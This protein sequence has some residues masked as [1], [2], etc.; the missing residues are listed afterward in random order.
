MPTKNEVN[1]IKETKAKKAAI[2]ETKTNNRCYS[3]K[4]TENK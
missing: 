3:L 1:K 2:L 4:N